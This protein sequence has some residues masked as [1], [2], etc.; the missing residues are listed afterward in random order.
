MHTQPNR[1]WL[2]ITLLLI[3]CKLP[4]QITDVD[5]KV[6]YIY[7]FTNYIEWPKAKSVDKFVIGV[8]DNNDRILTKL[9]YLAKNRKVNNQK[10]EVVNITDLTNLPNKNLHILYTGSV[11]N[12]KIDR[13]FS[14]I[15]DKNTLLITD[16]TKAKEAVMINFLPSEQEGTVRFE[17]NKKNTLD[18]GLVVKPD[19]LLLG[20]S[21]ID[22]R[23][24]FQEKEQQLAAEK[25]KLDKSIK[26]VSEQRKIINAQN[27][28]IAD[29]EQ[30]ITQKNTEIHEQNIQLQNLKKQIS[31]QQNKLET[32]A[33][34]INKKQQ[35]L[36]KKTEI[37]NRQ[38]HQIQKQKN[39]ILST[40]VK[41]DQ[42]KLQLKNQKKQIAEQEDVLFKQMTQLQL[43]RNLL[44]GFIAMIVLVLSLAYF[45][46]RSFRIKQKANKQL[47]KYN[48][49]IEAAN[50]ELVKLS[51]VA[52][53]TSNA[54]VIANKYGNI[55]WINE[56]FTRLFGYEYDELLNTFG[57]N[58]VSDF[59]SSLIRKKLEQCR[60]T[61][62]TVNYLAL[63]KAKNG[64]K[65]WMHSSLTPILDEKGEIKKLII[66]EA[67]V[68]DLKIAEENIKKQKEEI[69]KQNA[70]LEK[71]RNHLETIVRM[72]TEELLIAKE[73]AEESNRL[74]SSFIANMSHEIRTPM[75][76]VLGFSRILTSQ[77]L[78]REKSAEYV[79]I[80]NSNAK[81]L[82]RL[83]DDLIDLANMEAG[84]LFIKKISVDIHVMLNELYMIYKEKLSVEKPGVTI[85]LHL[86]SA[87]EKNIIYTD[88]LRINQVLINLLDNAVKFTSQG[89]I[90][91]GYKIL[92]DDTIQFYV[93][94]TGIGI[95]KDKHQFIFERFSKIENNKGKLYRG[96]GLGLSICK[97]IITALKGEIGVESIVGKGSTFHF[98]IRAKKYRDQPKT[99][100]K[101]IKKAH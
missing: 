8:Y 63:N 99:F 85:K 43:Q 89:K 3:I 74:K 39:D 57:N 1:F 97:M 101:S 2:I 66:I 50:Q 35:L 95:E 16:N 100:S 46:Y 69:E 25:D 42:Q 22:V 65:L 12:T 37:L 71:Y 17:I 49:E 92:N 14:A 67:N 93:S 11:Y 29:N 77:K 23:K 86:D 55:E 70:E 38:D 90:E 51:I 82:I 32:L 33:V 18:A 24:L 40:K 10:I 78:T 73:K 41:L 79:N 26:L 21:Y 75:N 88:R 9:K 81:S 60:Q 48:H 62:Q 15:K 44:F 76:A 36:N 87:E 5:V 56:G 20:G 7:R 34:N 59:S 72:R 84:K 98:S 19:I 94:D 83:I 27:Q 45:I 61:K 30:L 52:S 96:T 28:T 80:I 31:N 13:V 68:T 53:K 54:V 4:A 64:K 91:F 6:A 58:L 47:E